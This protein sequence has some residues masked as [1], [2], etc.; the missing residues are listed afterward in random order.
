MIMDRYYIAWWNV[1]N[2]FDTANSHDRPEWLQRRLSRELTGWDDVILDRKITQLSQII[3]Q[4]NQGQGPDVLGI[5]EVEN[6]PVMQRLVSSLQD[7]GRDYGIAHHETGDNRG[8]DVGF[9][10]DRQKF[11]LEM[12]FTHVVL[13]RQA[14]RDLFQINL[15]T[16]SGRDL[17]L[18]GNHWPSRLGGV[19]ESEPYRIVAGETLAYWMSRILEEKGPEVAVIVMGDFNDE[20]FSRSIT[21]YALSSNNQTR[22]TN[23]H[24][25]RLY[26]LMW[27]F[28]AQGIASFYY[29]NVP[30]LLDQFMVSRGLLR[31][32]R[33]FDI[34]PD[35][36]QIKMFTEMISGGA[37][38]NP[39]RFGRPASGLNTDGF[40]D[41]YP[42]AMVLTER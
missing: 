5:C 3:R 1:E 22:V 23:A 30:Y 24:I 40:S 33:R 32:N 34:E 20:P 35:S 19:L 2:L 6:R 11:G 15:R 21:D 17:I 14:T 27:P 16:H 38:P 4:M 12:K 29:G 13:K 8:I 37:Y 9:I 42:I 28:L 10:Y 18:V 39:I 26:N 31:S 36:V 41:H 25:P 7:L